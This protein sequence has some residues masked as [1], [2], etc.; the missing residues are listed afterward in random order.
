MAIVVSWLLLLPL[1]QIYQAGSPNASNVRILANVLLEAKE[2]ATF[3]MIVFCLGGLIFYYLLFQFRLV[4]RWLSGW[5]I[6]ALI[7]NVAAGL[8]VMFG[9]FS[10]I[11][12]IS[13]VLQ[14]P[15]GLQEM[16]LAVWLI[17]KGFNPSAI[18]PE[19]VRQPVIGG[20][21]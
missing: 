6:I 11:S 17:V 15:I 10:P 5:G 16:V 8:L 4:P 20:L 2:L 12:T 14:I 1:S 9:F 21:R 7:M 13:N 19:P 18:A 3:G